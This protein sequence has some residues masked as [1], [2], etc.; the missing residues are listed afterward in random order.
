MRA[1]IPVAGVGTRLRPHT[2]T[3][4][5]P[6]LPVAGKPI[7]SFL[8]EQLK[9]VGVNDF[10][11][12]IG[13]LGEKIRDYVEVAHPNINKEF[14][15]QEERL[16]LGHAVWTA[17]QLLKG[18]EHCFIALGDTI[19]DVDFRVMMNE[20]SSCVGVR[21]VDDP[22]RFGV[23]ELDE[24]GNVRRVVEKPRN[25]KSNLALVGLYKCLNL[26]KLMD[27]LDYNISNGIRT[28]D[29]FQLTDGL[30]RIIEQGEKIKPITVHNWFDCGQINVLLETNTLMLKKPGFTTNP[31]PVFPNTI[32]IPPVNIGVSC[33]IQDSIV[34]PNVTIGDHVHLQNAI[35]QD[36]IIGNYSSLK[37]IILHHSVIGSDT[38]IHGLAQSLNIGDNTE[39]D[40]SK[41]H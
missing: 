26:S 24:V 30:M 9:D 14:V 5:K 8:I 11:F 41:I 15:V 4:P 33:Q 13:Y 31:L 2:Y 36:A 17:R 37:E 7:I 6:L 18:D 12:V 21:K 10:V 25:P 23:A 20:P 29:E 27:A 38:S 3:Q 19:Y 16:G 39:I 34:G 22:R 35:V 40:F 28:Y 1:L 32:I